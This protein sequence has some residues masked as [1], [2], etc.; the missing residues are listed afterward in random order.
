MGLALA[1]C[2]IAALLLR[3]RANF[4]PSIGPGRL[5]LAYE[6]VIVGGLGSLWGTL[7][8]GMVLGLA[9]VAGASIN[10]EWQLLAGHLA[11]LAMLVIRLARSTRSLSTGVFTQRRPI[12]HPS[13]ASLLSKPLAIP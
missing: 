13:R 6:A 12:R 5:I 10:P 1:I 4:D 9:Q 11:F 8:G 2:A 7:A 3:A